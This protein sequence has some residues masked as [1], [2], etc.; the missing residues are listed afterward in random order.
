IQGDGSIAPGWPVNGAPASRAPDYQESPLIAS[1]RAGGAYVTWSD[2]RDYPT[3]DRDVYAQHL[4]AGGVVAAG[5]PDNGLPVCTLAGPQRAWGLIP[6]D[7]GGIVVVW[8]DGRS[9]TLATYAQRL[10]AD[11]SIA[12]GWVANGLLVLGRVTRGGAVADHAG[13]FYAGAAVLDP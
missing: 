13:G 4:T 12:P 2:W 3:H 9:G 8:A 6:D 7:N 5:W 1:D 11:G 10:Q